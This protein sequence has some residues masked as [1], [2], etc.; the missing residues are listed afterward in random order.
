MKR[1]L[2][3]LVTCLASFSLAR[4]DDPAKW[5]ARALKAL[6]EGNRAALRALAAAFRDLPPGGRRE[7]PV[8]IRE[9]SVEFSFHGE[10]RG[11]HFSAEM[12]EY[13]VS[14]PDKDYESLLVAPAAELERVQALRPLFVKLAEKKARRTWSARLVWTED[15]LPQS[16]E[17]ADLLIRVLPEERERFLDR[18]GVNDAGLGGTINVKADAALLPRKRVPAKLLLTIHPLRKID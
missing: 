8:R 5:E 3:A 11:D 16:V 14:G 10:F 12:L 2:I 15:G 13:L 9:E 7:L 18:L 17:L 6:A 4:A 1:T